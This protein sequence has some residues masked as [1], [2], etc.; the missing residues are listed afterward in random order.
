MLFQAFTGTK[1]NPE[2]VRTQTGANFESMANFQAVH[3]LSLHISFHV[4]TLSCF[5]SDVLKAKEIE[6]RSSIVYRFKERE[7]YRLIYEK[8]RRK[9]PCRLPKP[10]PKA[11]Y[12]C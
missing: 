11:E 10:E 7:N 12:Q 2:G 3:R 9:T 4:D 5:L 8:E 1:A 6:R